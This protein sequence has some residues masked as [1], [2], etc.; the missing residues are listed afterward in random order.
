[1]RWS[2]VKNLVLALAA[3]GVLA[4][5][6]TAQAQHRYDLESVD[7]IESFVG[8]PRALEL[9]SQQGFVVT[10][11]Q[12][13]QIFSAYINHNHLNPSPAK[14]I[15]VDSA[16][17]TYHVLF[18]DA[19]KSLEQQQ[20]ERLRVFS[21]TLYAASKQKSKEA[22]QWAKPTQYAA[23]ALA[24][25][26]GNRLWAPE[27]WLFDFLSDQAKEMRGRAQVYADLANFAAVGMVLQNEEALSLVEADDQ[28]LTM[29]VVEKLKNGHGATQVLFFGLPIL[30]EG[31][32]VQSFYGE[33]DAL[34]G[35]FAARQWY[36]ACAFTL[37]EASET[38]RA[39]CLTQLINQDALLN[40]LYDEL[41]DPYDALLGPC[42]DPGVAAYSSILQE[43]I[44]NVPADPLD[45]D[46]LNRFQAL[47]SSHLPDAKIND[48]FFVAQTTS[49]RQPSNPKSFRLLGS[50]RL[51][52][53]ELF[54]D[55][56]HPSI[57]GRFFPSA[58]DFFAVAPMACDA[59]RRSVQPGPYRQA[60][61]AAEGPPLPDSLHGKALRLFTLL[62]EPLPQTSPAPLRTEA[63]AD[64]QLWTT[65]GAWA[66]QRHTWALQAKGSGSYWGMTF[67]PPGFVSP[68][69]A[70]FSGLATLARETADVL[71]RHSSKELDVQEA[72]RVLQ[73]GSLAIRA[74][75]YDEGKL[76]YEYSERIDDLT[77]FL[78]EFTRVNTIDLS[79]SYERDHFA[80]ELDEFALHLSTRDTL[81]ESEKEL[82]QLILL[83]LGKGGIMLPDFADLCDELAQIAGKEVKGEALDEDD[84]KLIKKYG[85]RIA[86]FHFYG[87]NSW[88]LPLDDFPIVTSVFTVSDGTGTGEVLYAG[89]PRP[90]ALYVIIEVN[91]KPVLHRGAVFSYREFR[92]PL[93]AKLDDLIWREEVKQSNVPPPPEFT[94]SFRQAGPAAEGL[95]ISGH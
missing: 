87:G 79:N 32:R 33:N 54:Q 82:V 28:G 11:Q 72:C 14:F 73:Q 89:L 10:N 66:E 57:E 20:A 91:G 40:P 35:Y 21:E 4:A 69:P 37:E 49:G 67:E 60:I 24:L 56:T 6:P 62:H 77:L 52:S 63:W 26:S 70:F 78:L 92:R 19:V 58:T 84:A 83:P 7:L 5:A 86:Y 15:T 43:V 17:H 93:E 71:D 85:E 3:V 22:G 76:E 59:A 45:G 23:A 94:A 50:R 80:D 88:L 13:K 16:W 81:T 74:L 29:T 38:E 1:M 12:F 36:A 53:A 42:D 51:P 64:K 68:Y 39:L 46:T 90:E 75:W 65:L 61:L 48:Q 95:Q 47:A 31:F 34:R 41:T 8:S 18:E 30:A 9:L 44:G 27:R 25:Q 2:F 55:L